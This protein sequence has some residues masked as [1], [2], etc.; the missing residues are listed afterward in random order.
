M[1]RNILSAALLSAPLSL[2]GCGEAAPDDV[3]PGTLRLPLRACV[4]NFEA[5]V[6]SGPSAGTA[7]VGYAVFQADASGALVDSHMRTVEGQTLPVTGRVTGRDVTLR[8]DLGGGRAVQGTGT[9]GASIRDCHGEMRGP[10]TGPMPGDTG[11]WLGGDGDVVFVPDGEGEL[12][13]GDGEAV[14]AL[15]GGGFTTVPDAG[16]VLADASMGLGDAA[17]PP[18]PPPPPPSSAGQSVM[19]AGGVL[20]ISN[21]SQHVIYRALSSFGA[22][23]VFA[24][25]LNQP[26]NVNGARSASR[27]NG[28]TGIAF[29]AQRSR[30]LVADTGNQQVR[31]ISTSSNSVTTLVAR[32]AVSAA[33]V[34]AGFAPITSFG[35]RGVGVTS[36]GSVVVSD[37]SNHCLWGLNNMSQTSLLAGRPQMPG[38]S[39]GAGTA[40]RFTSPGVVTAGVGGNIALVAEGCR[41]RVVEVPTRSVATL[42]AAGCGQ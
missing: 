14:T 26:G 20:Y 36:A 37:A 34:A 17:A 40:A 7:L 29:D 41:L 10:L 32:P 24:G 39:D 21:P 16:I 18:P 9:L 8:F 12:A 15:R 33:S 31:A 4:V 13:L 5:T 30:L 11:D 1:K 2:L 27:F 28:P 23:T 38:T 3:A 6:R 22:L 42:G 25:G 35:T 19:T